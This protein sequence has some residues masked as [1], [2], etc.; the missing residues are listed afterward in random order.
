VYLSEIPNT[1]ISNI[2]L[3]ANMSQSDIGRICIEISSDSRWSHLTV[4]KAELSTKEYGL[5]FK[6][7]LP[8][9]L[10]VQLCSFGVSTPFVKV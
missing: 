3:G 1:A 8:A 9:A 10:K 5:N 6:Q 7:L 2:T 4:Y